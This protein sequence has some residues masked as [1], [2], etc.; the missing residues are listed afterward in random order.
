MDEELTLDLV[1]L[2]PP[3]DPEYY[4]YDIAA[5]PEDEGLVGTGLIVTET[6]E[7]A[8]VFVDGDPASVQVF[9][10]NDTE[11]LSLAAMISAVSA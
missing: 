2:D 3:E 11:A 10:V 6:G 1:D 4:A 5:E 8:V 9:R 7:L